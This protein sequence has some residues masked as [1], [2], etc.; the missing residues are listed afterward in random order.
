VW[1]VDQIGSMDASALGLEE[2]VLVQGWLA[3][4]L[5]DE[6]CPEPYYRSTLTRGDCGAVSWIQSSD[7]PLLSPPP[8]AI[9]VQ[10]G[11]FDA[12]V[13]EALATDGPR[14][15]ILAIAPRLEWDGCPAWPCLGWE[16][17]AWLE[18]QPNVS[19]VANWP[20][21]APVPSDG[22]IELSSARTETAWS[23]DSAWLLVN[24]PT[25]LLLLDGAT[26]A[27][28]RSYDAAAG[29]F[30]RQ[31]AW[32]DNKHFVAIASPPGPV[33]DGLLP[34]ELGRV[35]SDA[36]T[37][38]EVPV[39]YE[40]DDAFTRVIAGGKGAVAFD[41]TNFDRCPQRDGCWTFRVWTHDGLSR[42]HQ[43]MP[44]AWSPAG[45]RLL[46]IHPMERGGGQGAGFG[47]YSGWVEVLAW[48]GLDR[49]F[50]DETTVFYWYDSSFDPSGRFIASDL[51]DQVRVDTATGEI[52]HFE[53]GSDTFGWDASGDLVN[54]TADGTVIAYG[55]SGQVSWTAPGAGHYVMSSGDGSTIVAQLNDPARA[56]PFGVFTMLR[57]GARTSFRLPEVFADSF[58]S[59]PS[60]AP[61]GRHMVIAASSYDASDARLWFRSL[62]SP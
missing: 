32:V 17:V 51:V 44:V 27:V 2:A 20:D 19:A 58:V 49:F 1:S 36:L 13:P 14:Q 37:A 6:A 5:S 8:G 34:A 55:P 10:T 29:A 41:T 24:E 54:A 42:E 28:A 60:I 52:H 4:H 12:F 33:H 26:G 15:G 57:D 59:T 47:G 46:V 35:D 3:A 39:G 50:A 16:V 45:D 56:A 23:P 18:P 25:R 11:A 61:D 21:P 22:W 30:G 9:P 38:I 48:P 7:A 40:D 31:V 62:T 43:G 53:T